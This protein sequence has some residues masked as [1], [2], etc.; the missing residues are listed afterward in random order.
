MASELTEILRRI[1]AIESDQAEIARRLANIIR[2][3]LVVE[4]DYENGLG[5]IESGGLDS[6]WLPIIRGLAGGTIDFD[7][8]EPGEKC[9]LLS[10]D[11]ETSA[12]HILPGL[13]SD[14]RPP[15]SKK[16]KESL[17]LYA[18]GLLLSYDQ[19]TH[20]IKISR[21]EGLKVSF[22]A[23]ELELNSEK[24][25]I[26]NSQ[27][28]LIPTMSEALGIIAESKTPTDSGPQQSIDN[29]AKLPILKKKLESFG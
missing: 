2:P 12:G 1:E 14:N 18:D 17:R 22:D 29:A 5:R 24:V 20:T 4:V 9:L 10:P 11:G 13:Y 8:P 21:K 23:T 15:P 3:A 7:L 26:K 6:S 16:P 27:C 19:E 28:N 25:T